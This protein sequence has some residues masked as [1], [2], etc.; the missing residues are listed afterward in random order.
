MNEKKITNEIILIRCCC[1]G[2]G[3]FFLNFIPP[4]H[5]GIWYILYNRYISRSHK[6]PLLCRGSALCGLLL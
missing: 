4:F 3:F 2:F 5:V 1:D 6:K